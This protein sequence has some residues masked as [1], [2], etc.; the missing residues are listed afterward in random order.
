MGVCV[1]GLKVTR[2]SC[3]GFSV[4]FTMGHINYDGLGAIEFL[5]N[6][7]SLCK[8]GGILVQPNHERTL[9]RARNP[10]T[11]MFDHPEYIS[12]ADIATLAAGNPFTTTDVASCQ[13]EGLHASDKH[14]YKLFH[15]SADMLS[16][17]IKKASQGKEEHSLKVVGSHGEQPAKKVEANGNSNGAAAAAGKDSN[18]APV[19][20]NITP[21]SKTAAANG[22][23]ANGS[24]ASNG[25]ATQNGG[26][27][28]N[29]PVVK[30]EPN[31]TSDAAK[32][33]Q[34]VSSAAA[35]AGAVDR[36]PYASN[37]SSGGI[38]TTNGNHS[39]KPTKVSTFEALASH[40]WQARSRSVDWPHPSAPATLMFAVDIRNRVVPPLPKGICCNA[41]FSAC[42]RAS[43]QEL[44]DQPLS[45]C[46]ERVQ[47]AI[48]RVDDQYV[49]S[50]LD[51]WEVHRGIPALPGGVFISAWWKLP[52]YEVD[53]GWGKPI[54][55]GPIVSSMTEFVL[56]LPTGRPGGGLN[57]VI[58]L[59]PHEMEKFEK[60]VQI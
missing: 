52:F 56:M 43:F 20:D 8:G 40:I 1:L 17:L 9:L 5:T 42:A 10:P 54:F 26:H 38:I 47:S 55:A 53:F 37:G 21:G 32:K 28:H 16:A 29:A 25:L 44:A 27:K 39:K 14:V 60:F 30:A 6:Y 12:A 7:T 15:F 19:V 13:F 50:S 31:G 36:S 49:R 3:G 11:P 58:A 45:F 18:G 33:P 35:G 41:V 34:S 23:T 46:V 51:W 57:V 48:A 22:S 4:G 24:V 59:K 2:F